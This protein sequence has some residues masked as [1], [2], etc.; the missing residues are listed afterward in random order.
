MFTARSEGPTS[1]GRDSG[2]DGINAL[3]CRGEATRSLMSYFLLA[4]FFFCFSKPLTVV[5]SWARRRRSHLA[6]GLLAPEL[7]PL[8]L[9]TALLPFDEGMKVVTATKQAVAASS[10]LQRRPFKVSAE[11]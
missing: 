4:P 8:Q 3:Q 10:P 11:P 2:H 5:A 9:L 6:G 7:P 1:A